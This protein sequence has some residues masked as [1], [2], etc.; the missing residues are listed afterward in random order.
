MHDVARL[1]GVSHQTVS[2]VINGHPHI[3]PD[4]RA[5]VELAIEELGYRPNLA[6]RALVTKR[7]RTIGIVTTNSGLYGPNS[8]HRTVEEAAR[9]AGFF[10]G[11]VGLD[12]MSKKALSGAVDH[13]RRQ[14]VEGVVLIAGQR[15]ALTLIQSHEL[16]VPFVVVEGDLSKAPYAVGVD[17]FRGGLE[18]TQHLVDLGHRRIAHIAGPRGWNE[19][20]ARVQGWRAALSGAG[21][22][23]GP[24]EAGDWSAESGYRAGQRIAQDPAVTAVFVANDEMAVGLYLALHEAGRSIP[25]EVS[26]VGFDGSP[27]VAFLVPP[28]TT[29]RQ[30]F[31]LVGRRAVDVLRDAIEGGVGT[32]PADHLIAPELVVR[33]STATARARKS[34]RRAAL[35]P[36]L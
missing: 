12:T 15:R 32:P 13:L 2:R 22:D 30:N 6:A 14:S 19:A 7:S 17:S 11:S 4:T 33:H 29:V 21:L 26:V 28:L 10:A 36:D 34:R 16:D 18:A 23:D 24:L 5:K 1:A 3:R 20:D 9:E 31:E 8:I 35:T 25:G 27:A